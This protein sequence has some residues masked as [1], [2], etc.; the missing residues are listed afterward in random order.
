LERLSGARVRRSW[1]IQTALLLSPSTQTVLLC[2]RSPL[3]KQRSQ[4]ASLREKPQRLVGDKDYDS[5]LLDEALLEQGIWMIPPR[6]K[7]R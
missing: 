6:R 2:A 5:D 4:A 7:N 1:C 3:S